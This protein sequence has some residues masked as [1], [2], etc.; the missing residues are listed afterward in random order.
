MVKVIDF[1]LIKIKKVK[2]WAIYFDYENKHYFIIGKSDGVDSG[3]DLYERK[4]SK[5]GSIEDV[6]YIKGIITN[7][8][9]VASHY[10]KD[11]KETMAY[12]FIDKK[13][14]FNKL[15]EDGFVNK[16]KEIE[17]QIRINKVLQYKTELKILE[18]RIKKLKDKIKQ[19]NKY[20]RK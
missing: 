19:E 5:N 6:V 20:I 3:Y 1:S 11:Y 16:T 10:I 9:Y 14:F 13:Y 15:I 17:V 4:L 8:D 18:D 2:P 7:N 12:K